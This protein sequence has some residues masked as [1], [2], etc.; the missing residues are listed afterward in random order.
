MTKKNLSKHKSLEQ[1]LL[2]RLAVLGWLLISFGCA[3]FAYSF[4]L[5][6]AGELSENLEMAAIETSGPSLPVPELKLEIVYLGIVTF[7]VIG[8]S[9]IIFSWRRKKQLTR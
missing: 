2:P 9:C 3:V 6:S 5:P 7:F 4:T 1:L 8:T